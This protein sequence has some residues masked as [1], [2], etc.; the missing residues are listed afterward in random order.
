MNDLPEILHEN[1]LVFLHTLPNVKAI[2]RC[3]I[4]IMSNHRKHRNAPFRIARLLGRLRELACNDGFTATVI[5]YRH[6]DEICSSAFC[7]AGTSWV[8]G[9]YR[10]LA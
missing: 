5:M 9:K 6:I 3:A 4:A 1:W 8:R 2:A 10:N 7:S